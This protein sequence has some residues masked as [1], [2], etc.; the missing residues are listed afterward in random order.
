MIPLVRDVSK[1]SECGLLNIRPGL[2]L[3]IRPKVMKMM[4]EP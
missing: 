1:L 3:R 4:D 2:R